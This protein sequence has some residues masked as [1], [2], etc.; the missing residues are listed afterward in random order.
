MKN[1]IFIL[2]GVF[3]LTGCMTTKAPVTGRTQVML[4]SQSETLALGEKSYNEFISKAKLSKNISDIN[5]VKKVGYKLAEVA[6]KPE[7]KWEFSLVEDKSVNAF[8][9]PGGKV[10]VYTGILKAI[11]NEAQLATVVSHEIAHALARH[12]AER[13]SHSMMLNG[14][15]VI[16][17]A[18]INSQAPEYSAAFSQAY[19]IG[20]NLGVMLPYSRSHEYEADEIGVNLMHKAGYNINEAISFWKNMQQVSSSSQI[21][22]LSTH[23][24][25]ENRIE[26]LSQVIK[27]LK[28]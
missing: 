12:G 19:G 23:P 22:F 6:N 13:M 28:K 24:L 7:Y 11:K 10:V 26:K 14:I 16:S 18:F 17:S 5:L 3:F 25:S 27:K 9:L 20:T 8:C 4:V 21:E 15:G 1:F 2:L